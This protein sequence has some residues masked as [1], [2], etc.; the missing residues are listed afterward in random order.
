MDF[1]VILTIIGT[2]I[3][4]IGSNIA[5]ISWLRSDMKGFESKIETNMKDFEK[6]NENYLKAFE[7]KIEG[8]KNEIYKEMRD[9]HGRLCAIDER[10]HNKPK[11]DP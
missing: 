4:I 9:F 3:A 7:N 2:T 8:W 1:T 5:L 11:T 10:T 6:K